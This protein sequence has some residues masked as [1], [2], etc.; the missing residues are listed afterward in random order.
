MSDPR[1]D[2]LDQRYL[3]EHG[4]LPKLVSLAKT[5]CRRCGVDKGTFQC[6]HIHCPLKLATGTEKSDG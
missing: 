1:T 3:I 6:P 2:I 4:E 5:F